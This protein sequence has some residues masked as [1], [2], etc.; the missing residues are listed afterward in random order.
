MTSYYGHANGRVEVANKI[1]INLI[2]KHVNHKP[3][4]WHKTLTQILWDCCT[5]P[6]EPTNSTPFQLTFGHDTVLP[7]EIYLQ[8]ASG[9]S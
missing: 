5:S 7:V 9:G 3:K 2:R 8:S 1:V 4:N 6:K